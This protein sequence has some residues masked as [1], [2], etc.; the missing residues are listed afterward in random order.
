MYIANMII[1]MQFPKRVAIF[2]RSGF[3]THSAST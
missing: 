2:Y 3:A 1:I